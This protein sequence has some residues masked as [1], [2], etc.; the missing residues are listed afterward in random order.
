MSDRPCSIAVGG[1]RSLTFRAGASSPVLRRSVPVVGDRRRVAGCPPGPA[2]CRARFD[3]GVRPDAAHRPGGRC[4]GH[5]SERGWGTVT[6]ARWQR[7]TG[8][9]HRWGGGRTG[10]GRDETPIS[11]EGGG[12]RAWRRAWRG[13]RRGRRT[14]CR[15]RRR[16]PRRSGVGAASG[17]RPRD[18]PFALRRSD[19]GAADG[20]RRGRRGHLRVRS[21]LGRR[22]LRP[23]AAPRIEGA[24]IARGC[25]SP[26]G[27]GP[28]VCGVPTAT[29]G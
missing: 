3:H 5:I 25:E 7:P 8:Q 23:P 26:V 12:L 10:A 27:E 20:R 15:G 2:G 21:D 19:R 9:T 29:F 24:S 13:W 11:R 4:G 16:S 17:L 14:A 6:S 22:L 28:A 18:V 1:R